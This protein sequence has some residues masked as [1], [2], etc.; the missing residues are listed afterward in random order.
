MTPVIMAIQR[1]RGRRKVNEREKERERDA[2]KRAYIVFEINKWKNEA[3]K[4]KAFG[5]VR[6]SSAI[7]SERERDEKPAILK[8]LFCERKGER[9][10]KTETSTSMNQANKHKS[11]ESYRTHDTR[12]RSHNVS[13][14]QRVN[15]AKSKGLLSALLSISVPTIIH[16]KVFALQR[17]LFLSR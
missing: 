17:I 2:K 13:W 8:E 10:R 7:A 9:A 5:R 4:E 12:A 16:H 6:K 15:M 3:I 1:W 14:K 11:S